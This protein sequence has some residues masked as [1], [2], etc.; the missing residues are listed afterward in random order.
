MLTPDEVYT[1]VR[2]I[3][4]KVLCFDE[5]KIKPVSRLEK[6]LGAEAL[7]LDFLYINRALESEFDIEIQ[8]REMFP[9]DAGTE[10]NV[11]FYVRFICEKIGINP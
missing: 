1:R 6:D 8:H 7:E 4:A 5:E 2:K 9:I 11:N 10:F 3:L